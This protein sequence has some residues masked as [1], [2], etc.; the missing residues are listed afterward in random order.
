MAD[1]PIL[2]Y[3]G[4]YDGPEID[5]A[6]ELA[7]NLE[8]PES[9]PYH[10]YVSLSQPDYIL[11]VGLG[12]VEGNIFN[13]AEI[14][15][16]LESMVVNATY[17]NGSIVLH[18]QDGTSTEPIP[19]SALIAGL[20]SETRTIA[21]IDLRD[22]ITP[23]ELRDAL[24]VYTKDSVDQL[25]TDLENT[26]NET[27]NDLSELTS[28]HDVQIEKNTSDIAS[29]KSNIAI[30]RATL[31]T[32]CKNRLKIAATSK[33]AE[34]T[35]GLT[36]TVNDDKSI[37]INGTAPSSGYR[38]TI[39]TFAAEELRPHLLSG[40]PSGGSGTTYQIYS[41]NVDYNIYNTTTG[42]AKFTPKTKNAR[43]FNIIIYGNVLCNNIT[44]YPM[45]RPADITDSTYE[46]YKPSL[47]EQ[48]NALIERI[49]ALETAQTQNE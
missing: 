42:A 39:G 37:T 21:G 35:N 44:F 16:P 43:A 33:T 32:Q 10:V 15:L 22:D 41:E 29:N 36:I 26:I 30:N 20:V 6:V 47:Q 45:I 8:N 17:S 14:D 38:L 18:L 28:E 4:K 46:E 11:T 12:D 3:K 49:Q 7:L 19:I 24:D 23:K 13:H 31:G 25:V 27:L 40:C 9:C 1:T 48:I 5:R 2:N 34:E